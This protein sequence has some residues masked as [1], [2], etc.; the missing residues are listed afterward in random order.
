MRAFVAIP[1]PDGIT[2]TLAM[3]AGGLGVGRPVP[4][5]NMHVTLAFLEDLPA[6]TLVELG[7]QLSEIDMSSFGMRITGLDV[8][9]GRKP[10]L[11]IAGVEPSAPLNKLRNKVRAAARSAG[12]ALPRARFRPHVT[13]ARFPRE[14]TRSETNRIGAFL[15]SEGVIAAAPFNVRQFTLYRSRLEPDGAR[16]ESLADYPLCG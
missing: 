13:L 4:P 6:G 11:L 2:D 15:A 9:G 3:V 5:E 16:Y 8:F 10:R 1:L 12:I 7:G 14:I